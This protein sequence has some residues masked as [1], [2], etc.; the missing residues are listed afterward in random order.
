[1]PLIP[2]PIISIPFEHIGMDLIG[3]IP[4]S[5]RGLDYILVILDYG[6]IY[7]RQSS[8]R[9]P[10]PETSR[11]VITNQGMPF[12]SLLMNDLCWLLQVKHLRS[13]PSSRC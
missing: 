3:P 1:M 12:M 6:T 10:P 8:Y 5:A 4:K 11:G 9:K 7:P 2:L 13:S